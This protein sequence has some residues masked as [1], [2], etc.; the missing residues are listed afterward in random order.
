MGGRR[1]C[2]AG[3]DTMDQDRKAAPHEVKQVL[4]QGFI[5]VTLRQNSKKLVKT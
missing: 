3:S 4:K 1:E 2:A 5:M